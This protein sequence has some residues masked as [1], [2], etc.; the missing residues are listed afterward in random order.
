MILPPPLPRRQQVSTRREGER[1]GEE[2]TLLGEEGKE[3]EEGRGHERPRQEV[4]DYS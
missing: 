3:M 1:G 2:R 4:V